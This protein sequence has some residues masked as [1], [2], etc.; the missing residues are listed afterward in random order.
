MVVLLLLLLE[1]H[2]HPLREEAS[3]APRSIL[4]SLRIFGL[5]SP[6]ER[7][8]ILFNTGYSDLE[9][10]RVS[11]SETNHPGLIHS[12]LRDLASPGTILPGTSQSRD[13][14]PL[15]A[16]SRG[17]RGLRGA[18]ACSR[19][20]VEKYSKTNKTAGVGSNALRYEPLRRSILL[21]R[22]AS[23]DAT[24]SIVYD[25]YQLL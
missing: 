25:T 8:L 24:I 13:T 12:L 9:R 7:A 19:S 17:Q 16:A 21:L 2:C 11:E 14:S 15:N 20:L 18:A 10:A 4:T 23:F 6:P 1:R 22:S 5:R 3:K